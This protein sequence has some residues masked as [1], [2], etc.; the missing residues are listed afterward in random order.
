MPQKSPRFPN[1][2]LVFGVLFVL[3]GFILML[4]SFGFLPR[5]AALWPILLTLVGMALLYTVLVRRRGPESYVFLGMILALGGVVLFL[6]NTVLSAV[7]MERIWPIFM[8]VTGLS[9]FGYGMKKRGD[10]RISLTIPGIS[11]FLLS[12]VF[13]PFSLGF[14]AQS[15]NLF[16]AQWWPILLVLLGVV[17]IG[18]YIGRE[19]RRD[20]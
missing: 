3:A 16:V 12:L 11:I 7:S 14:V 13:L 6:M 15:F 20:R 4:R 8:S 5:L 10:A 17:L 1:K 2:F 9:L 19:F 18:I